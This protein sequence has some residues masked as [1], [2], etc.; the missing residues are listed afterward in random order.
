MIGLTTQEAADALG[1]SRRGLRFHI[2]NGKLPARRHGRDWLIDEV[3]LRQFAARRGSDRRAT[4]TQS[5]ATQDTP[6]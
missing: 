1:I 6:N 5:P 4:G 2:T 3:A